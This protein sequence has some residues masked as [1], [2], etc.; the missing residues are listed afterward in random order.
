MITCGIVLFVEGSRGRSLYDLAVPCVVDG[1]S[2][3]DASCVPLP[4]LPCPSV[5]I[6]FVDLP[7]IEWVTHQFRQYAL[8]LMVRLLAE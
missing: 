5:A 3:Q 1:Y 6:I 7:L 4:A 2:L 8:L